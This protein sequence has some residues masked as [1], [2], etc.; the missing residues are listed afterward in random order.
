MLVHRLHRCTQHCRPAKQ[1]GAILCTL[2]PSQGLHKGPRAETGTALLP[3]ARPPCR[4]GRRAG[5]SRC[6]RRRPCEGSR[7]RSARLWRAPPCSRSPPRAPRGPQGG[8][9]GGIAIR[10]LELGS[11]ARCQHKLGK[12]GVPVCGDC[13]GRLRDQQGG[14][15]EGV[16][17]GEAGAGGGGKRGGGGGRRGGEG[18]GGEFSSLR[19]LLSANSSKGVGEGGK[20]GIVIGFLGS[21]QCCPPSAQSGQGKGSLFSVTA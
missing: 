2:A 7:C 12:A 15:R 9:S 16:G 18:D 8:G 11:A 17:S 13:P 14:E 20:G 5:R 10:F 19:I 3:E 6:P 4:R 21:R 1:S